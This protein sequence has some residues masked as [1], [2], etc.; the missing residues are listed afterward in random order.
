MRRMKEDDIEVIKALVKVGWYPL[1]TYREFDCSF[2]L[3]QFLSRKAARA[4]RTVSSYIS[5]H[6]HSAFSSWLFSPPS[7]AASSTPL[8]WPSLSLCSCWLFFSS[9]PCHGQLGSWA[10]AAPTGTMLAA[11]TE[12]NRMRR[13]RMPTVESVVKH[14]EQKRWLLLKI[15]W[16]YLTVLNI[17]IFKD[18]LLCTDV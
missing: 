4:Q 10:A 11:A 3:Q 7:Y 1:K 14:Q 2:N 5:S 9:S 6:V 12:A 16:F 17:Y 15:R 13:Y 8:S 18:I